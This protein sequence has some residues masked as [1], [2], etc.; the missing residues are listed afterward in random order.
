MKSKFYLKVFIFSLIMITARHAYSATDSPIMVKFGMGGLQTNSTRTDTRSQSV[1]AIYEVSVY[2]K[3]SERGFLNIT[4][5]L[6][7]KIYSRTINSLNFK[8]RT[9]LLQMSIGYQHVINDQIM[10]GFDFA[11]H[12]RLTDPEP[13][14]YAPGIDSG[15]DTS[16]RDNTEYGFN[17]ILG[18]NVAKFEKFKIDLD[19][20][21]FFSITPKTNEDANHLYYLASLTYFWGAL[22]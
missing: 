11:T 6:F 5:S 22:N 7:P 14:Y 16:A 18:Y 19:V 8:E 4:S 3:V 9:H 20:K 12:Y 15:N 21:Y 10:A 1:Q 13:I 2:G 17:L